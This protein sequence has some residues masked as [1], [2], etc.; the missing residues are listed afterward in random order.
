MRSAIFA[1][2]LLLALVTTWACRTNE[3]AQHA[4]Q[5][6]VVT[7]L[8]S[9]AAALV[10]ERLVNAEAKGPLKNNFVSYPG[11]MVQFH[12]GSL[13]SFRMLSSFMCRV[14]ILIPFS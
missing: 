12:I 6:A 7:A 10:A 2:L 11:A 13:S 8:G 9:L 4:L 14:P 1:T 5:A 3:P